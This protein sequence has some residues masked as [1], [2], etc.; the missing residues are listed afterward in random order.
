MQSLADIVKGTLTYLA[1]LQNKHLLED[2]EL[3]KANLIVERSKTMSETR[4]ISQKRYFTVLVI[5]GSRLFIRA[6]ARPQNG[7][8]RAKVKLQK[9]Y[10]PFA[11]SSVQITEDLSDAARMLQEELAFCSIE[12][13]L[14]IAEVWPLEAFL[15]L[16]DNPNRAICR[17]FY[18]SK[19]IHGPLGVRH[20]MSLM[21]DRIKN[22]EEQRE[23]ESCPEIFTEDRLGTSLA[24]LVER[25][26]RLTVK[27]CTT[28]DKEDVPKIESR[29]D[30]GQA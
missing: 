28:E 9:S 3:F 6:F 27:V 11:Q 4:V 21:Q 26:C 19:I 17:R 22:L 25:T 30:G 15:P 14:C 5:K 24:D 23:C 18:L 10:Y 12:E 29:S 20:Q 16:P 1:H 2:I 13:E 7:N 8:A